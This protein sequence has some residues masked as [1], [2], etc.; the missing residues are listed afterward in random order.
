MNHESIFIVTYGRTGSTLLQGVLNSMPGCLV[1]GEN[2]NAAYGLYQTWSSL[3]RARHEFG[4]GEEGT[5]PEYPWYGAHLLDP[6]KLPAKLW[7]ILKA[8]LLGSR[9][10]PAP[11]CVGFKEIRYLPGN[12]GVTL[13]QFPGRLHD[14][15]G[16][17]ARMAPKP[18]FIFLTRDHAQVMKSAWWKDH[19]PERLKASLAAFEHAVRRWKPPVPA[20]TFEI[21]YAD[22]V[23]RGP[24]LEALFGFMGAPYDADRVAEVMEREHSFG[25]NPVRGTAAA[26]AAPAAPPPDP[27]GLRVEALPLP[28]QVAVLKLDALPTKPVAPDARLRWNGVA[29]AT[30]NPSTLRLEL[31]M[32]DG[33]RKPVQWGMTSPY[34]AAQMPDRPHAGR[35]RYRTPEVTLAPGESVELRLCGEALDVPLARLHRPVTAA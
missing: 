17:L 27:S 25:G 22:V 15:L 18:A 35:A 21:D 12:L 14:Y 1:R 11:R 30:S 34:W 2:Y 28:P 16:F 31:Q 10:T 32:P 33:E 8:Q 23:S 7:P 24:K 13:E 29:V 26:T 9:A 4:R 5:R 20:A 19:D 3:S 6:D